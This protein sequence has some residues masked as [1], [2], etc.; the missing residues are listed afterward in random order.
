MRWLPN[1]SVLKK[2]PLLLLDEATVV[3]TDDPSSVDSLLSVAVDIPAEDFDGK[4]ENVS[5]SAPNPLE[6]V[7]NFTGTTES[8]KFASTRSHRRMP[9]RSETLTNGE[10]HGEGTAIKRNVTT[11][12]PWPGHSGRDT[13]ATQ[14]RNPLGQQESNSFFYAERR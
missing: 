9:F 3:S 8:H 11:G 2:V 1:C 5:Q 7:G 14:R 6:R 12:H 4:K 13:R 10:H